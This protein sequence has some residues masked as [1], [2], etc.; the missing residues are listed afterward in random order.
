MPDYDQLLDAE[1]KAY[2]ARCDALYPPDA[3]TLDIAGQR[4][5]YDAMCADF[6]VGRPD[7]VAVKDEP[8]GG[9]PCRHYTPADPAGTVIYYHGGGF[10]VGGLDSHDSICAEICAKTG[11]RVVSVDYPL[12][13]EHH[14]PEDFDAAWRAYVAISAAWPGPVVLAGDSAG[15]NLAA[16]IC[17]KARGAGPM[18]MGQVLIYPGLGGDWSWPSYIEHADAPQLTTRDMQFYQQI[19][20]GGEPPANDPGCAPLRDS[21]FAGLVPTVCVSAQCDPLASDS[22]V[23][24]QRIQQAGGQ[25]MWIDEAGLVHGNL[26]ARTMSQRAANSFERICGAISGLAQGRWPAV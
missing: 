18:P 25:A 24:V 22:E 14:Y 8:Q 11:L 12:A 4:R 26:R 5:V 3:V 16:A 2:L 1:M 19:R 23:Y 17:H 21:D 7:G 13:P 20:F 15:G 10:V 9:V 6:D